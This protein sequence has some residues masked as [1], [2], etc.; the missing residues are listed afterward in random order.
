MSNASDPG[1]Q[2]IPNQQVDSYLINAAAHVPGIKNESVVEYY[3]DWADKYD[4]VL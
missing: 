3:N 4:N 2:N 1:F